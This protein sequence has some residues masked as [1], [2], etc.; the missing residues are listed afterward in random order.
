MMTETAQVVNEEWRQ[1]LLTANLD[2][3]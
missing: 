2:R 1:M 3:T